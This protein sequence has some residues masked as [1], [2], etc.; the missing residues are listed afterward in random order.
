MVNIIDL[1]VMIVDRD[2]GE[3]KKKFNLWDD[4]LLSEF[5]KKINRAIKRGREL[6]TTCSYV[7]AFGAVFI[8]NHDNVYC[9]FIDS[10]KNCFIYKFS[11]EG[12]L[13]Q[14]YKV[15]SPGA[16]GL[17]F[18]KFKDNKYYSYSRY[19]LHI[20]MEAKKKK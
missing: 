10:L 20:F 14:V 5:K 7:I 2:T 13:L 19:G 18:F 15:E 1:S 4:Y 12:K 9:E 3:I 6:G 8:D 17:R 16:G 11:I